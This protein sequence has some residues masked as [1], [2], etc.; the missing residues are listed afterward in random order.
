[1]QQELEMVLK[2]PEYVNPYKYDRKVT[3]N[4]RVS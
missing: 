3:L 1:M 4:F 2:D